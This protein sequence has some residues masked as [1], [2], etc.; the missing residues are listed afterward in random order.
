MDVLYFCYGEKPTGVIRSQVVDVVRQLGEMGLEATL[1]VAVPA[2]GSKESGRAFREVMPGARVMTAAP[3]RLQSWLVRA[4]SLRIAMLLSSARPR[5]LICRNAFAADLVLRAR[6]LSG[7]R[8]TVCLDGRG[9]LMAEQAEYGVHPAYS[10]PQVGKIEQR[11][12]LLADARIAVTAG[13]VEYWRRRYGYAS[14]RHVVIPTTLSSSWT[15]T[16]PDPAARAAFRSR[17]GIADDEVVLLYAGSNSPWQGI[18]HLLDEVARGLARSP[19]ARFLF[20]TDPTPRMDGIMRESNGRFIQMRVPP[21]DVRNWM[22]AADYG[23]LIR[24]PSE[25]NEVAFPTKYAEY[26]SAGLKVISNGPPA[27]LEHL[28]RA[29]TG[30]PIDGP[31]PWEALRTGIPE[32][33]QKSFLVAVRDFSKSSYRSEYAHLTSLLLGE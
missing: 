28:T 3:T 24:P 15:S 2:R 9:A 17:L 14:N 18:G 19:R 7:Y 26:L 29:E 25:T 21:T 4:E 30:V 10:V 13:L 33:R 31:L 5:T 32:D 23:L 20:L 1:A 22:Q 16:G 8:C 11:A 6:E 12:V 27:V